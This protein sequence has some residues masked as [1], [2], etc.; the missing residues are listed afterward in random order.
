MSHQDQPFY[1]T[2]LEE[3]LVSKSTKSNSLTS[4]DS[5]ALN[6]SMF[7]CLCV[8]LVLSSFLILVNFKKGPFSLSVADR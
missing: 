8:I 3:K 5:I 1:L 6:D 4:S 7:K 2:F